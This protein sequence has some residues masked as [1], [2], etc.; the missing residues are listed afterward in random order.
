[1]HFLVHLLCSSG[2]AE[3]RKE[4]LAPACDPCWVVSWTGAA[5]YGKNSGIKTWFSSQTATRILSEQIE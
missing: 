4:V 1:M 5:S 2:R 3:G